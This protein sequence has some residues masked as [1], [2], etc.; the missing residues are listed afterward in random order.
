MTNKEP[1][2]ELHQLYFS[3][4]RSRAELLTVGAPCGLGVTSRPSVEVERA[5]R[6][7]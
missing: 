4:G 3:T 6:C 5:A 7:I 1:L 2:A